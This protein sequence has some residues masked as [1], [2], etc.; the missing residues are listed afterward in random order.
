MPFLTWIHSIT[1]GVDHLLCPQILENDEIILTNA[2][3]IF[4][5]S[6]AEYCITA[7]LYFAKDIP[8]LLSNQKQAVWD[9][10]KVSEIR[11][12]TLGIIGYGNIGQSCAKLAKTFGMRII[13][14]RKN[15]HYSTND[16]FV[17]QV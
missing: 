13:G 9:K 2:K 5:E 8:R 1:A 3:G 7:M 15:P 14:L 11:G 4:N 10:Y 16:P 12:K 17:D 6:L